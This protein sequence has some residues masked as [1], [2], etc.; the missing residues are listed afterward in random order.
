M[1]H[2]AT[3]PARLRLMALKPI[4]TPLMSIS[5]PGENGFVLKFSTK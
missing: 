4:L 3:M 1:L 5:T 2:D